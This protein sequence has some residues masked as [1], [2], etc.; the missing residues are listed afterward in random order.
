MC[1]PAL[2]VFFYQNKFFQ[3]CLSCCKVRCILIHELA[4][5]CQGC[6]KNGTSPGTRD[7]RW[8]AGLYLLIR[9]IFIAVNNQKHFRLVLIVVSCVM[10]TL[11]ATLRPYRVDF[12][13]KADSV[14]VWLCFAIGSSY[15]VNVLA[16][17]DLPPEW[18]NTYGGIPLVYM[19][20]Y[21][22]WKLIAFSV[23]K[24]RSRMAKRKKSSITASA[25]EN[26]QE[27]TE[28]QLAHR[29]LQPSEYT[30][31]ITASKRLTMTSDTQVSVQTKDTY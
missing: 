4:N 10:S 26:E 23:K 5:I 28:D 21:V 20:C 9:I 3:K 24:C 1:L 14:I 16:Y 15:Y 19:M 13:N 11:V 25:E 31:L 18:S 22:A 12:Y 27:N 7:Y 2:F 29:I 17:E 30:P 8:F 6:F